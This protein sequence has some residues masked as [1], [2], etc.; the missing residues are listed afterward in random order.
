MQSLPSSLPVLESARLQLRAMHDHDRAD[1]FAIYGDPEVMRFTSDAVFPE[2]ATVDEML[3]SVARLRAEGSALEWAIE[4]KSTQV[5][6]GTCGLHR[7][8][9]EHSCAEVGC[10]LARTAWGCGY[11]REALTTLMRHAAA[12]LGLQWLKA[13]IDAPNLRSIRL[14]ESLGFRRLDSTVYAYSLIGNPTAVPQ[15]AQ[16]SIR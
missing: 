7:F 16:G 14:F 8:E 10:V 1:L 2:L 5:L 13:D 6:I 3:R 15:S 12:G 11:M 4:L 9:P